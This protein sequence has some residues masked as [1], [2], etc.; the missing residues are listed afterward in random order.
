MPPLKCLWHPRGNIRT[1]RCCS[2]SEWVQGLEWGPTATL[3]KLSIWHRVE[4][5]PKHW[6]VFLS[7][8]NGLPTTVYSSSYSLNWYQPMTKYPLHSLFSK[9]L[10]RFLFVLFDLI[11]EP[12]IWQTRPS[13]LGVFIPLGSF[14]SWQ[15][16]LRVQFRHKYL[17]LYFVLQRFLVTGPKFWNWLPQLF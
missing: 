5:S 1:P 17:D 14:P 10:R 15:L 8:G 12:L 13:F 6:Q 11:Y 3:T 2:S 16:W 7:M 9:W 4:I